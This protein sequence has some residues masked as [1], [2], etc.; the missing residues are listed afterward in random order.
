M[1]CIA[2]DYDIAREEERKNREGAGLRAAEVLQAKG[3][4]AKRMS[5][6]GS[7][8]SQVTVPAP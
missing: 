1:Y 5:G 7:W 4:R 3:A 6:G 8:R 2:V